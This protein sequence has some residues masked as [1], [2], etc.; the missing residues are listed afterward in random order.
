MRC[1]LGAKNRL[2]R[3]EPPGRHRERKCRSLRSGATK[4]A[5]RTPLQPARLFEL[6]LSFESLPHGTEGGFYTLAVRR[7][8]RPVRRLIRA[9]ARFSWKWGR[10]PLVSRDDIEKYARAQRGS[11]GFGRIVA[12]LGRK[13]SG[14]GLAAKLTPMPCLK[15]R[16]GRPPRLLSRR[17]HTELGGAGRDC[18]RPRRRVFGLLRVWDGGDCSHFRPTSRWLGCGPVGRLLSGCSRTRQSGPTPWQVDRAPYRRGRHGTLGRDV[19]RGRLDLAGVAFEP[20]A[21]SR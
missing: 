9:L 8:T 21:N 19:R 5:K 12:G 16:A 17:R 14:H 6:P 11:F 1:Q 20:S 2:V 7:G 10:R 18:R 3:Y 4:S 13:G 15:L